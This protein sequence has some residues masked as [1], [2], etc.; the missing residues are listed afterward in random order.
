[1]NC[2]R[3]LISR[4]S[5]GGMFVAGGLLHASQP[6]NFVIG[7]N[8]VN[9][10]RAKIADQDAVI[11]QLKAA[12]VRV[13]R[14]GVTPDDKGIDFAK[15]VYAAGIKIELQV[16]PQY[17]TDAPK[18]PYQP[19]EFPSMWSGSPLSYADPKLSSTYFQT[20]ID[21]LE[22]NG[23]VLAAFELGN[24]INWAAFNPEFPLPGEGK[25]F[26][27]NDLSHDP[28]AKQVAKG[29]L[30]YLKILA[31]LKDV[32]DHSK[33]NRN[34]PIL[35][36]GL[37]DAADGDPA[38]NSKKEDKVSL[39]ATLSFMRANGLDSLV[40]AY[41]IHTYP[42]STQPGNPAAD[43]KRTAKFNGVTMA[44]CR[45]AGSRDGKPCWITEWGFP[46]SDVSCPTNDAS[47]TQLVRL[48]RADFAKAA[49]QGKLIGAMLFAWDSDPWSKT[50]DNDSVYRCG[51]L[52]ES[53]REAIA[54]LGQQ[55]P[56]SDDPPPGPDASSSSGASSLSTNSM[57]IRVGTALVARGPAPNIADNW[58]TEI[59]LPN[60]LFRGFTAAGTTFA[61]DGKHP[62]DMGGAAATVLKP[63]PGGSLDSC[64]QWIQHVELEGKTLFGWVHNETACNYA[65]GGQTHASMTIAT[66]TDYGLTWKIKG[67]IIVGTDPPAAGKE[68]GDSC[69]T[70]VRGQDGYDYAYCLH[71]GCHSW[72]GGYGFVARA[73]I[74]DPGPGKWKKY[75]NGGWT[76][77][78]VGG[79]SSP[80]KGGALAW[81]TTT[82]QSV[83][84]NWVKGGLGIQA[85]P[86]RI[87]F[88]PVLSQ[89]IMLVEPGD[90]SRKNGLELVSYPALIDAHT[91]LNQLTDHWLMAYMYLN[92]G[93]NFGKRYLVFR[94]VD[95]SWSRAPGESQVGEMLTHWYSAAQHDHWTTTAPVPGNYSAYKLIAQQGYV[96][97][98]PDPKEASVELEECVSQWPGH[99]DHLLD[100][101]GVCEADKGY[102]FKRLRA[103]GWVYEK[104]QANSK[105]LYR[106]YSTEEHSH[107]ASND[108][109]C[110]KLGKMERLLGYA[111]SK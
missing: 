71:N 60:G 64:G 53:G 62:Y 79:K 94:P 19:A 2:A 17:P 80:I 21:R 31:V 14:C 93:E 8:V 37:V 42:S 6:S 61:I 91:G 97:T 82:R 70:V 106:C 10:L 96:M 13:I 58:F 55:T 103:A 110:G 51:K 1:M 38:W 88:A 30:Q 77:P 87:N 68:T 3:S 47:R 11:A 18:R 86:D 89:P 15:R 101:K 67:P 75:F 99:P 45:P 50:V 49:A 44:E 90:W 22:S 35:T 23:I 69:P 33:L 81:W 95:I 107:F 20:L 105:A 100:K 56:S 4:L 16:G 54:P 40:D 109:D 59:Q 78:G 84:L 25:V 5:I 65:K 76:E 27:L 108:S 92:P 43:T 57:K 32:R 85:S 29:F 72:D 48:M 9:P 41:A 98:A 26:D 83:G 36:A 46:N 74:S 39:P 63:G 28:E 104:P 52:T 111:L 12:G 102:S 66:S 73:P 24:E 7:V 34:T